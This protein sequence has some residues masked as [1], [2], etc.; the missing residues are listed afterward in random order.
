ME[1]S[2]FGLSCFRLKYKDTTLF[3]DP[4]DNKEVG[5]SLSP[6]D[7]DIVLYSNLQGSFSEKARAKM[8][9]NP[10]REASGK[11]L[12][13][14]FEPGEYEVGGIFIRAYGIPPVYII[15]VD[16]VN[17]AFLGMRKEK[18]PANAFDEVSDIDYLIVPVGDAGL[19]W[20][21]KE[22][23]QLIKEIEPG[24]VIPCCYK[25]QGMNGDYAKL[26]SAK[27]FF[28]EIGVTDIKTEK[29]LKLENIPDAEERKVK[30]MM[31]S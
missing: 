9:V 19:V 23:D 21:A 8:K 29:K 16:D 2:Y 10:A 17:I 26:A 31:F 14:I 27:D 12:I 25:M 18:M 4:F 30:Y 22:A 11:N 13:E 1:L 15:T 7:A 20:N 5:I 28:K 6:Q 24:M 3:T